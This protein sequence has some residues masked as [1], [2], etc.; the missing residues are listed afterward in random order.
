MSPKRRI[1]VGLGIAGVL[2]VLLTL[3]IGVRMF[4]G[5]NL[6]KARRI[7]VQ[8]QADALAHPNS[9]GTATPSVGSLVA[10]PTPG[11]SPMTATPTSHSR[12]PTPSAPAKVAAAAAAVAPPTT[13]KVGVGAQ[14][15]AP[16]ITKTPVKV[17]S[18]SSIAPWRQPTTAEVN[19]AISAVHSLVPFFTPTATQIATSGIQVCTAF[20]EGQSFSTVES[21]ALS[22]IGASSYSWAIPQSAQI[23][24]IETLVAL[25]CPANAAKLP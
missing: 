3:V 24:A 22:M 20:N 8:L 10:A 2:T 9:I 19:E 14:V 25:Y 15:A 21:D 6:S 1:Q 13:T 4:E 23:T 5:G 11:T 12:T 7:A 17:I 18:T 16:V